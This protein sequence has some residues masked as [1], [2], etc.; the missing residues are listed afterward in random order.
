M[1][2]GALL[3]VT[4][5]AGSASAHPVDEVVQSTYLLVAPGRLRLQLEITPGP[6][7]SA[8]VIGALD[9]DR[10]GILTRAEKQTY[11]LRVLSRCNLSVDGRP[12]ALEFDQ[13]GV[14]AYAALRQQAGTIQLFAHA[15]LVN[16]ARPQRLVFRNAYRPAGGSTTANVFADPT[17]RGITFSDQRRS[18]DGRDFAVTV[19]SS[20]K[21]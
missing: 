2:A 16:D 9:A 18:D 6:E 1:R 12:V 14:P 15:P 13:I 21:S 17:V 5:L 19:V 8:T 20:G 3:L 7:V 11:A 10:D 4:V